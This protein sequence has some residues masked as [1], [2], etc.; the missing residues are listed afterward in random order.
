[1]WVKEKGYKGNKFKGLVEQENKI[2]SKNIHIKLKNWWQPTHKN[3]ENEPIQL[4]QITKFQS[5]TYKILL[6]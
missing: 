5:I 1:M 4:V 6:D 2:F 3:K